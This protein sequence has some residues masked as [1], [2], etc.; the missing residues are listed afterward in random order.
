MGLKMQDDIADATAWGAQQGLEDPHRTCIAGASYGGYAALM[1]RVR[2]GDLYQCGVAWAAVS[3]ISMMQDIWRSDMGE[4]WRHFG[5]PVM[6]GDSVKDAEQLKATSALQQAARIKRPLLLA[7]GTDDHRVPA[8]Q[9]NAR[10]EAL[11]E[12][13]A[14]LTWIP[15]AGE[16]RGWYQPETRA[17]FYRSM[18]K[19]LDANIGPGANLSQH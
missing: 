8:A 7:H 15:Y 1:G 17:S 12:N 11:E 19:F 18:V 2:Y 5:M 6:V 4:E 16:G 10:R 14:A 3:D 9:A 13:H